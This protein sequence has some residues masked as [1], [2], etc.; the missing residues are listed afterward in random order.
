MNKSLVS[1]WF[2]VQFSLLPV[3]KLWMFNHRWWQLITSP[4]HDSNLFECARLTIDTKTAERIWSQLFIHSLHETIK[5][6]VNNMKLGTLWFVE[7]LV[8]DTPDWKTFGFPF[9]IQRFQCCFLIFWVNEFCFEIIKVK[10]QFWRCPFLWNFLLFNLNWRLGFLF[11]RFFLFSLLWFFLF[12]ILFLIFWFCLILSLFR[13]FGRL[14][15]FDIEIWHDL[16]ITICDF[17][18]RFLKM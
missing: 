5:Q 1:F 2:D 10:F 18:K 6:V 9:F 12:F 3:F 15:N 16:L 14:F 4:D 13:F 8:L 7:F 11:L 17:T